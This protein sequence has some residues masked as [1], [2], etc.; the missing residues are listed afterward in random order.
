[1]TG[2]NEWVHPNVEGALFPMAVADRLVLH[3]WIW[4]LVDGG[5]ATGSR[6]A[7]GVSWLCSGRLNF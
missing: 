3:Y 4:L 5:V 1:M 2:F 6:V 7:V